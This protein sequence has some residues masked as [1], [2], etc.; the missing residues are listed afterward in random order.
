M[1]SIIWKCMEDLRVIIQKYLKGPVS[2][3][4]GQVK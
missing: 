2:Q 3:I 4:R 1:F